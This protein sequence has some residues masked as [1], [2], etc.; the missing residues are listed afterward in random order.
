MNNFRTFLLIEDLVDSKTAE[1][2]HR[3]NPQNAQVIMNRGHFVKNGGDYGVGI[4]FGLELDAWTKD[5]RVLGYGDAI[6]AAKINIEGFLIESYQEESK[7]GSLA[8][9]VY[10]DKYSLQQQLQSMYSDK[11]KPEEI[12]HTFGIDRGGRWQDIVPGMIIPARGMP[13]M[14]WVVV[15]EQ[16]RA[17]PTKWA[18]HTNPSEPVHWQTSASSPQQVSQPP[19]TAQPQQ[20]NNPAKKL[21]TPNFDR[22]LAARA[23][24]NN[25]D[26]WEI[27]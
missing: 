20:A 12:R 8:Q 18:I 19:Q 24:P 3:T 21:S 10:G 4:Y 26:N 15:Y 14:H 1:A 7:Y 16:D 23:K 17:V 27:K 6:I 2:Y 22:L 5:Q 9:K 13:G 11:V 25:D